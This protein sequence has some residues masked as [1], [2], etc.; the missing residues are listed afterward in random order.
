M[1]R[2]WNTAVEVDRR[3]AKAGID[4]C[5]IKTFGAEPDYVDSNMDVVCTVPLREVYQRAFSDHRITLKDEI[6]TRFYERNKLMAKPV[7]DETVDIHLHSNAGWHNIEFV[8]GSQ[9]LAHRTDHSVSGHVVQ[10]LER[11][12]DA[13]VLLL[14]VIFE[15]FRK[16]RWDNGYLTEEDYRSFG[17]EYGVSEEEW[18]PIRAAEKHV[19]LGDL[20]PVWRHY[21]RKRRNET[22]ISGWNY[23]LHSLLYSLDRYRRLRAGN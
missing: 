21:Y 19:A 13:R 14:Q 11:G 2:Y 9:I 8:S 12:L 4:Y 3:L 22:S 5:I 23:F 7:G 15:N 16:T 17:Q 10:I 20:W 1:S 6:K 18:K